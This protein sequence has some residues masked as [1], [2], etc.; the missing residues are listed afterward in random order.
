VN[1]LV[2]A[3]G[4]VWDEVL[5]T[6]NWPHQVPYCAHQVEEEGNDNHAKEDESKVKEE[7]DTVK[8]EDEEDIVKEEEKEGEGEMF[9]SGA[10]SSH[11]CNAPG[12]SPHPEQCSKFWLCRQ[13]GE[14]LQALLFQCPPN[15]QFNSTILRC[16]EAGETCQVGIAQ[17]R[18]EE[19]GV[20]VLEE[21]EMEKFFDAWTPST[22]SLGQDSE[23]GFVSPT[24]SVAVLYDL[25]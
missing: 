2:C 21:R 11:K 12:I 9:W 22:K 17:W 6:C 5:I 10:W 25:R 16:S 15:Y 23:D 20:F 24:Q 8:E 3:P 14:E 19:I 4:T 7:E 1:R 13:L 18:T